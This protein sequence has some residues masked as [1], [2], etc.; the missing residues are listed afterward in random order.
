MT[1]STARNPRGSIVYNTN[2]AINPSLEYNGNDWGINWYGSGGAG[3][4]TRQTGANFARNGTCV[5]KMT[6]TTAPTST[7]SADAGIKYWSRDWVAGLTRSAAGWLLFPTRQQRARV[8]IIWYNASGTQIGRSDGPET[9]VQP[10]TWTKLQAVFT[11]PAG[12]ANGDVVFALTGSIA[13]GVAV[14]DTLFVDSVLLAPFDSDYFD[15]D[16]G[17]FGDGSTFGWSGAAGA[18]SSNWYKPDPISLISPDMV[19]GT[20]HTTT[21][22]SVAHQ[23]YDGSVAASLMPAGL[24]K[25]ILRLW[26]LTR[27]QAEQC[28]VQHRVAGTW[29]YV[30]D[31]NPET[32]M[33][34]IVT[35]DVHMFNDA[36]RLR[37][38]VEIPFSEIS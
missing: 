28:R 2:A 11:A 36:N 26:F 18:S 7:G 19:L 37:W 1:L 31:D 34:Y 9:V 3:T 30:D 33:T 4:Y 13:G 12:A 15:G 35:G 8:Y 21:S 23:L 27:A 14:N 16:F 29:A 10:N 22:R 24:R 17:G 20:D 5:A 25:G 32:N 38:T 6:W